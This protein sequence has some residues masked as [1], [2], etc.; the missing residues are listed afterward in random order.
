MVITSADSHLKRLVS[1][2][3]CTIIFHKIR[4]ILNMNCHFENA[5]NAS[6]MKFRKSFPFHIQK[7]LKA[8]P[9]HGFV[10]NSL[11]DSFS[12][13]RITTRLLV[14]RS[15]DLCKE[16]VLTSVL[17]L[18]RFIILGHPSRSFSSRVHSKQ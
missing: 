1:N 14:L 11:S 18:P 4:L 15:E 3:I 5:T 12:F 2:S 7:D 17:E 16:K 13:G 9:G 8:N 6:D 10:N